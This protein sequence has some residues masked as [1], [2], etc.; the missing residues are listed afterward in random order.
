MLVLVLGE[1]ERGGEPLLLP[2]FHGSSEGKSDPVPRDC[3]RTCI[4]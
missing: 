4:P 3:E 1:T 2:M